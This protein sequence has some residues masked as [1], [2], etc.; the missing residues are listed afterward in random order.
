MRL[1]RRKH[2]T[3]IGVLAAAALALTACSGTTPGAP[4]DSGEIGDHTLVFAYI[5]AESFPY[6]AGAQKFKEVLEKATDGV[7]K[8]ELYP[9][10]QLGG[11]RDINESIQEGSVHIGI[12]A[13]ALAT[14]SPIMNL[15]ELPFLIQDQDH[16]NR[17]VDSPVAGKLAE[18]IKEEGDFHVL[19]WFST[20]DS[21]IQSKDVAIHTPADMAGLKLRS[22][23]NPALADALQ[24][25]GANPTPMPY[26][27]VYT[28]VQT[29]V[30]EG[31]TLDWG[32]VNSMRLFEL[33][34][35]ATSPNA[36]FLAEP[37][38]V[39]VS[40]TFWASLNDAERDAI[41][42][43]MQE[44]ASFERQHFKELQ[45]EAVKAIEAAGVEITEIDEQAFIDK[46]TPV[47]NKWA[48]DLKAE[49]ILQ[50]IL[51]LRE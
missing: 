42:D 16:M 27:E 51:D 43:A 34:D 13:G 29:G 15:L 28:G 25:L 50:A 46:L 32:S 1:I 37:R 19:D 49:D 3:A 26:G 7:M 38:P 24:A 22:I 12:G 20:G 21:S 48:A 47:W 36:A 2:S 45:G 9:G 40:A 39:I 4:D 10:G 23:E 5:T 33:I 8:V 18:R 11:E 31:A 41:A 6:H 14:L 44:A 17:I 30:I 35:H